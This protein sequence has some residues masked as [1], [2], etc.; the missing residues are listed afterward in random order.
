MFRRRV[1]GGWGR[2][3]DGES[4]VERDGKEEEDGEEEK[5]EMK[6]QIWELELEGGMERMERPGKVRVR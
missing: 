5:R 2:K 6:I 3:G 1:C 4:E